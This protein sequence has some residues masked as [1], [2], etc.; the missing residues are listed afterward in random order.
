MKSL[1]FLTVAL[2]FLV[3]QQA[4]AASNYE[5]KVFTQSGELVRSF[6]PFTEGTPGS[7]TAADLGA[8]GV[9]E[10]IVGAGYGSQPLVRVFRQDGSI[11]GEFMAYGETFRGG[12]NVA[13]CDLDGDGNSEIVTGA[14]YTGGPHVRIFKNDGTPTG[15]SFF[16]YGEAFRGGVNV[17][18]GDV[19]GDGIAEIIT[20]AGV[21]GGPHVKVF[22]AA[23]ALLDEAFS[24]SASE[25]TG[26]FVTLGDTDGDDQL[27][28][29]A[30][31]MA[32]AHPSVTIFAWTNGAL[33][34]RQSLAT[35]TVPTHGSP[36]AAFDIDNDGADEIAVSDGAFGSSVI[37]VLETVGNTTASIETSSL[38]AGFSLVPATLKDDA[39]N[40]LLV[41]AATTQLVDATS[42]KY[43]VVDISEQRLTAFSNGVPVNTFLVSTGV[44]GWN[45]PQGTTTITAKI[46]IMDYT[47]FYGA[48]NPNNY[49]LPDVQWNMRFRNHYYLHSAYWHNNFGH[50]MSHGCVN[51]SVPNAEWLFNWS[52]VGTTVTVQN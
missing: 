52:T 34:Y 19:T 12:V 23:G 31:P 47:W 41:L 17:T 43:I 21:T 20:G 37:D 49:S 4:Q 50:Q 42:E 35:G 45:T 14:G 10:I 9:A 16:A 36:L 7:V 6:V 2:S 32:Y 13:T 15:V 51:I 1:V 33:K 11:I 24:G 38:T 5:L 26:V 39:S 22:N 46:P 48:G 44:N 8:D 25:S 27:E 40:H 30:S 3:M 28:V 29:L 18:C